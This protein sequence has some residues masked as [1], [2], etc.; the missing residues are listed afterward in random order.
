MELLCCGVP[1]ESGPNR[2]RA[3]ALPSSFV[4]CG[5]RASNEDLYQLNFTCHDGNGMALIW[6]RV[7][8]MNVEKAYAFPHKLGGSL[9]A[10]CSLHLTEA[11]TY[12]GGYYVALGGNRLLSLVHQMSRL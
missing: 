9:R 12:M 11:T 10:F 3:S 6:K 7:G 4:R 1:T 2:P 5:Q 8:S